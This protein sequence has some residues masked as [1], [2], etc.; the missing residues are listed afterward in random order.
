MTKQLKLTQ[1]DSP[2][3]DIVGDGT[4]LL[5]LKTSTPSELMG[6]NMTEAFNQEV[7]KRLLYKSLKVKEVPKELR[8]KIRKNKKARRKLSNA[9][10]KINQAKNRKNKFTR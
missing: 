3:I 4:E 2:P 1:P 5:D 9:S 7:L 8:D 6:E 10:R